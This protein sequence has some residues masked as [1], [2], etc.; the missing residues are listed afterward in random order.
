MIDVD[1]GRKPREKPRSRLN[2]K[3]MSEFMETLRKATLTVVTNN[4]SDFA[5]YLYF[6]GLQPDNHVITVERFLVMVPA[7]EF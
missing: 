5:V 3:R 7:F 6:S 4:G 2:S 1:C